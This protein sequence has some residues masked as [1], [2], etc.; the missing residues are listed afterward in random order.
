MDF[1]DLDNNQHFTIPIPRI[2][3]SFFYEAPFPKCSVCGSS[4]LDEGVEYVIEKAYQKG[5]VIFEYA[6]CSDCRE[7]V[8]EDI[9]FESMM[10]LAHYFMEHG[11]MIE[12]RGR[13][14]QNFDNSIKEWI[15]E[16]LFTGKKRSECE[17]YQICAECEGRNL[18]VSFLPFMVSTEA[19]EE[20]QGLISKE[21]KESFDRFTREVLNPPVD[22]KNIPIII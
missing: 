7:G 12:R 18:V 2:F 8:S 21:T 13:L 6:M 16:C 5:E 14:M 1:T 4:L 17:N 9:S 10:N 20:I 11:D 22:L 19:I 3:H 15:D